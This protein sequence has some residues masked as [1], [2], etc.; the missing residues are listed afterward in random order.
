MNTTD[1]TGDR[2]EPAGEYGPGDIESMRQI[3]IMFK[4]V[5][6]AMQDFAKALNSMAERAQPADEST[7]E[8]TYPQERRR[9]PLPPRRMR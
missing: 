2:Y 4:P 8:H 6:E 1:P 5:L 3:A 7:S 9:F